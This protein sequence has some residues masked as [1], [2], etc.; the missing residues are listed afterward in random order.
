MV[1]SVR[2]NLHEGRPEPRWEEVMGFLKAVLRDENDGS[3]A[4][5]F[6]TIRNTHLDKLISDIMNPRY[7]HPRVP[8]RFAAD[9]QVVERLE[10]KW[11]ERFRGPYFHIEQHRYREL[12]RHGRLRDVT[13]NIDA[14]KSEDR[15]QVN[16]G[17]TLS[18]MEGNLEIEPGQ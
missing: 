4:I 10:R 11:I 12:A 9:L 14:E 2:A 6:E 16:N 13:L 5:E 8:T 15:W 7:R 3:R 18:E 1:D 17:E